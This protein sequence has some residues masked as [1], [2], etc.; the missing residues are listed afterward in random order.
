MR[1]KLF[2]E[3]FKE[4]GF[5]S[6]LNFLSLFSL[7]RAIVSPILFPC[8][9]F[10]HPVHSDFFSSLYRESLKNIENCATSHT[11]SRLESIP[12]SVPLQI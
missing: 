5:K 7:L 6:L 2:S 1:H 9:A 4:F 10:L 11:V 8:S 3:M 12:V